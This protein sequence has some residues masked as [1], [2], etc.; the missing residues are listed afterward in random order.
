MRA[1]AWTGLLL[2]GASLCALANEPLDPSRVPG[3]TPALPAPKAA[4]ERLLDITWT[5]KRLV[6]VGQQGVILWSD[7]GEQWQQADAPVSVMLTRVKFTD[8][9]N[10]WIMGYDEALLRS[11]DG[12]KS[13]DLAHFNSEGRALYDLLF[14][15]EQ[16]GV[17][18]GGYGTQLMTY[19]GGKSWQS[20]ESVLY[21]L[22]MH[23]NAIFRLGDGTVFAAGERGFMARSADHGES[24]EVLDAPYGGSLF[25]ALPY[26]EKGALVYGMR[27]NVYSTDDINACA[28]ADAETWDP[29]AREI[30][31]QPEEIAALGW[32]QHE[33]PT[34]ESLFGGTPLNGDVL[35]V[36]VNGTVLKLESDDGSLQ[37][38]STPSRET[39]VKVT[40]FNGHVLAVGRR[41]V[42]NLNIEHDGSGQ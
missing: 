16:R 37:A 26:G 14:L 28:T 9:E 19:D 13:W 12:G 42:Q 35:M 32:R 27:G 25:G 34:T 29:Y 33:S 20:Y 39:L 18:V 5:G 36:G 10:G 31:R 15:D 6:A 41:G 24:W 23:V 7:D 11:R 4:Q 22:G 1:P 3:L 17:A 40:R 38:V 8:A 2:A 21:D 30:Y